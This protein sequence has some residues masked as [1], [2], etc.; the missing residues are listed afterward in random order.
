MPQ[1]SCVRDGKIVRFGNALVSAL[2]SRSNPVYLV[3]KLILFRRYFPATPSWVIFT[4]R[5]N[6]FSSN[7]IRSMQALAHFHFR[8]SGT[9]PSCV[10]LKIVSCSSFS[11]RLLYAINQGGSGTAEDCSCLMSVSVDYIKTR[12]NF[13]DMTAIFI[14]LVLFS[15]A[16]FKNYFTIPRARHI[17]VSS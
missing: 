4:G 13:I 14:P 12:T 8:P 15:P 11:R 1:F 5:I 10:F 3:I 2:S 17:N 6:P 9:G 16:F 7:S